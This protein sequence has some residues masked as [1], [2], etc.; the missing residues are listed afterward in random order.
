M[1][2]KIVTALWLVLIII[3]IATRGASAQG[4]QGGARAVTTTLGTGFTYQGQLKQS[5]TT[6]NVTLT[7]RA[8]N[9]LGWRLAPSGTNLPNIIG[10]ATIGGGSSNNAT[11]F[12]ATV[13]GGIGNNAYGTKATVAGGTANEAN[14][15]YSFVAGS[16]AKNLNTAHIGVFL[17]ADSSAFDFFST[18]ANQFRVRSTGGAQFV[19]AIDGSGNATAG[20]Q[21][22]SGAGS[23]SSLSDRNVKSN[24][25]SVN[26]L[27]IL[28]RLAAM[29]IATWN[30]N[31]QD[32][33]IQHIGPMAQDSYAAFQ[34][35]EDDRH[36]ST[37]DADGVALAAIQGLNQVVQERDAE[38]QKLGSQ[39]SSLESQNAELV[40]QNARQQTQLDA[41]QSRIAI[42]EERAGASPLPSSPL[43]IMAGVLVAAVAV[44]RRSSRTES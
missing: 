36:I 32:A 25:K 4:P 44:G 24:I 3:P 12:G 11:G 43:V 35:G 2:L 21:V 6:D 17:F 26:G 19:T 20:V 38:I 5:A 42:L 41:M 40:S 13:G 7:L 30:Y 23:W 18:A 39:V 15:S 29:P 37:V 8:N 34:V 9:V 22:A 31:S 14:A 1:K 16:R 33:A 27:D 10:G 28:A